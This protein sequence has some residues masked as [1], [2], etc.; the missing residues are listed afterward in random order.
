LYY[1][2][3][4]QEFFARSGKENLGH[5]LTRMGVDVDGALSQYVTRPIDSLVDGRGLSAP[6]LAVLSDAVATPYHALQ[7]SN[8]Q[9]GQVVAV[10]GTGGIGSNAIQLSSLRGVKTIAIGRSEAKLA[11]ASALGATATIRSDRG[12]ED[13]RAI[14]GGHI[15]VVIQCV[16]SP[17]MDQLALEI[18]GIGGTVV[19]VGASTERFSSTSLDFIQHELT[20]M[21]SRGFTRKDI[22]DVIELRVNNEITLNHLLTDIRNF[23]EAGEAFEIIGSGESLRMII[24]PWS[25]ADTHTRTKDGQ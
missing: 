20:L 11:V 23:D 25:S 8:P 13:I 21:G 14:A 9:P 7:L 19:L 12:A 1:I 22:A 4:D 18:A 10:I 24:E 2:E 6:E 5:N 17:E 16:G 3:P 15:D